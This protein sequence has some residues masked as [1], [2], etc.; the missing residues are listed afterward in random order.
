MMVRSPHGALG[1]PEPVFAYYYRPPFSCGGSNRI[2]H[3]MKNY[4]ARRSA[5]RRPL[6]AAPFL[7]EHTQR[8]I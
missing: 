7:G 2:T 1:H 5:H 6:I 8:R 4:P 3:T